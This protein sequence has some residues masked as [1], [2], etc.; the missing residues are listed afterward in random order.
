MAQASAAVW[1]CGGVAVV[2]EWRWWLS[3]DVAGGR[4]E[5]SIAARF[6]MGLAAPGA[7]ESGLAVRLCAGRL[8]ERARARE[9]AETPQNI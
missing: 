5:L 9:I 4:G 3:G 2:A 7:A 1:R 8:P 6:G